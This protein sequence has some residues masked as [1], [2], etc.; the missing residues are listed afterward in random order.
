[1]KTSERENLREPRWVALHKTYGLWL[2]LCCVLLQSLLN[3]VCLW[4]RKKAQQQQ[5]ASFGVSTFWGLRSCSLW[6]G[7][8]TFEIIQSRLGEWQVKISKI[9]T[10][11]KVFINSVSPWLAFMLW[12]E[13]LKLSLVSQWEKSKYHEQ[14]ENL[15]REKQIKKNF[16][17]R[18]CQLKFYF[19]L[20]LLC[21]FGR[22]SSSDAIAK[23]FFSSPRSVVIGKYFFSSPAGFLCSIMR[24]KERNAK[25]EKLIGYRRVVGATLSNLAENFVFLSVFWQ[26]PSSTPHNEAEDVERLFNRL[27]VSWGYHVT[28]HTCRLNNLRLI[29]SYIGAI[30]VVDVWWAKK[31]LKI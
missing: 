28:H 11:K 24:R 29:T 27:S 5:N 14:A 2:F 16:V 22:Q 4:K 18:F 30:G 26:I 17:M 1:M 3:R 23:V 31:E 19:F 13:T 12:P 15:L 21:F 25:E 10:R 9:F 6:E 8:D 7:V 20:L